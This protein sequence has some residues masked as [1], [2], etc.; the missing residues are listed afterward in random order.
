MEINEKQHRIL[1]DNPV[2]NG[3]KQK[4]RNI[5]V[6]KLEIV[7]YKLAISKIYILLQTDHYSHLIFTMID[8]FI[9]WIEIVF[10]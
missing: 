8:S 1:G 7:I 4:H 6:A 2:K 9:K 10:I 5:H 3:K